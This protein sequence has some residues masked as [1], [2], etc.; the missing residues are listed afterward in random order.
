MVYTTNY[1]HWIERAHELRGV[2]IS[3]VV[4]GDDI[5]DI[6]GGS[7]S[8]V[9]FHGDLD[10]P[11]TMVLTEADYFERLRFEGELDLKLRSD[12]LQYSVV[13]VGYSLSDLNMRN[14]LYRLSLF[15]N[16]HALRRKNLHRSYI[17]LDGETRYKRQSSS[18]GASTRSHQKS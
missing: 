8:I 6:V 15:R 16:E 13:F 12:L 3:K 18:A 10:H 9:K 4:Y 11:D 17:F 14:M 2:P 7:V 5:A 1:D